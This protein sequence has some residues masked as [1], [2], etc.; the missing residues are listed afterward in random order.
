M[1]TRSQKK[2]KTKNN[3]WRED[4]ETNFKEVVDVVGN[5]NGR[6]HNMGKVKKYNYMDKYQIIL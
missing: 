3:V 2:K 4:K 1:I 5:G 6:Q